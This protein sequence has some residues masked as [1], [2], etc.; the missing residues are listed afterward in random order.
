MVYAT[1]QHVHIILF[2]SFVLLSETLKNKYHCIHI[3][4][5]QH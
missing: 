2:Y 1:S 4:L 5:Q 3:I